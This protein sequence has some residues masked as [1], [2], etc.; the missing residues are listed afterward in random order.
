M[1]ALRE[2]GEA[3]MTT[4]STKSTKAADE[5]TVGAGEAAAATGGDKATA[6]DSKAKAG[7]TP[8]TTRKPRQ[9]PPVADGAAKVGRKARSDTKQ[10]K[11]I[12]MLKG[13]D[14]AT[15]EE[16]ASAFGWQA[17]TVRGAIY[18]ALKKKLGLE[19]TSE[20]VEGRGRVYRIGS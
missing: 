2:H 10:A 11:L 13:K 3:S 20:K 8:T 4:K 14:G 17:H 15:V 9:R 6:V 1:T 5:A 12:A 16:I 7:K 18:G 19:V